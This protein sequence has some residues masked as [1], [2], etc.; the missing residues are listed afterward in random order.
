MKKW[1]ISDKWLKST[2]VN[3]NIKNVII[4]KFYFVDAY[5]THTTQWTR[6]QKAINFTPK[7]P[8]RE[9][10]LNAPL[11]AP[12]C[13]LVQYCICCWKQNRRM[14]LK[15]VYCPCPITITFFSS[16]QFMP[17]F[18]GST[19][20]ACRANSPITITFS[21]FGLRRFIIPNERNENFKA[22]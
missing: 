11:F 2:M 18:I 6:L 22:G 1:H 13:E 7:L 3:Q 4:L 14:L 9:T 16:A 5:K 20:C 10:A 15:N 8:W 19:D 17:L 12:T 21:C